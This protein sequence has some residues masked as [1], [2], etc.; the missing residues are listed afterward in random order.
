M[1]VIS[2]WYGGDSYRATCRVCHSPLGDWLTPEAARIAE[3]QHEA[4]EHASTGAASE[5][6]KPTRKRGRGKS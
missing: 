6:Q 1:G 4:Q 2:E 5:P 3:G